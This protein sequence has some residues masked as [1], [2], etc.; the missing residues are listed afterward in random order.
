MVLKI[1][2]DAGQSMFQFPAGGVEGAVEPGHFH[3][4][5][6]L[7]HGVALDTRKMISV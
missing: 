6:D 1:V 7:G 2:G 5:T 4:D 3:G